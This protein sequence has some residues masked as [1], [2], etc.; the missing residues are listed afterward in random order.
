[1]REGSRWG[2]GKPRRQPA[3]PKKPTI[4]WWLF[5]VN[6]LGVQTFVAVGSVIALP[7]VRAL[8]TGSRVE[9]ITFFSP[10]LRSLLIGPA[11]SRIWGAAH[12]TARES[13][14]WAAEMSLLPGFALYALALAGLFLSIWR[15]RHRLMLVAGLVV[16]VILTLG[17]SFFDGRWTYL[18]LFGHFPA[19][20][21]Q[22]IPG[23]LMLWV[24][25]LLAILAAGAV[26]D[27]VRRTEHFAAQRIP[28]WPGPWLRLAT[29]TPLALVLLEGWNMTAHPVVPAQPASMRTVPGPMLVLPTSELTD[30]IV[31]LW[32]TT[33]FQQVTNGGGS[34]AA[35]Q[36]IE[37]RT[38]VANFPDAASSDYLISMGV[39]KVLVLRDLAEGTPWEEATDRPVDSLGIRREDLDDAVV[40]YLN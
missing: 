28:P 17:T 14:G 26:D 2:A 11:E 30:Q 16:A 10:P 25:L 29:L 1:M 15:F 22:R 3:P 35:Q 5:V 13:L 37:L 20:F 40:F 27:L 23:R 32:T 19:A 12:T 38:R 9:E 39:T 36:Q 4:A 7:Y 24:T 8:N 6:A 18:P 21:D 33:R 34:F 31:Q